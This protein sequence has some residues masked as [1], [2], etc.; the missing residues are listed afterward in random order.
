MDVDGCAIHARSWA[1]P[2]GVGTPTVV[3]VHGLVVSSRYM[4]PVGERLSA[5][6]RVYAPDLP[7]FGQ[8][9]KPPQALGVPA[10][11]DALARWMSATG[12]DRAALVG[13]SFGCQVI[14][15]LAVRCP[16]RVERL[17]LVGPTVD[18]RARSGFGQAVRWLAEARR[19]IRMAPIL[20]ADYCR[21]GPRRALATFRVMLAD[22]IE[23]NLPLIH[24][25][26]L[27]VRGRRD[28]IVPEA[29]AEQAA[30]LLPRGRLIVVPGAGHAMNFHAPLELARVTLPF[31]LERRD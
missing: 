27:V 6:C 31:L 29:W 20:L 25:P 9:D 23:R 15:D 8:S 2:S 3:L 17:V 19:D 21:A 12:I 14:A 5:R 28:R 18:P 30:S 1:G 10:L 4:V 7:G 24:A 13:N 26:A 22:R 16:E 11:A